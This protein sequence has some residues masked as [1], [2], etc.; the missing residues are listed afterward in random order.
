M[1]Y[2]ILD[3]AKA[4]FAQIHSGGSGWGSGNY[5]TAVAVGPTALGS[6]ST[7]ATRIQAR[8]RA[9]MPKIRSRPG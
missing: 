3:D 8:S 9:P 2:E 6:I 5:T 1:R 4:S 7:S